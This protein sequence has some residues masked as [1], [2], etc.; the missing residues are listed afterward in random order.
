[1]TIPTLPRPLRPIFIHPGT[2][3]PPTLPLP[4]ASTSSTSPPTPPFIPIICLSASTFIPHGGPEPKRDVYGT[5]EYVQGSGD[6]DEL[7][8][9]GLKPG[10]FFR[11]REEI[12][13][14]S[15]EELPELIA[16]LVERGQ[17]QAGSASVTQGL[18]VWKEIPRGS[19]IWLGTTASDLPKDLGSCALITFEKSDKPSIETVSSDEASTS[20]QLVLRLQEGKKKKIDLDYATQVLPAVV[21]FAR[22]VRSQDLN[23]YILIRDPTGK[24]LS[25]GAAIC[26]SWLFVQSDRSLRPISNAEED[27]AVQPPSLPVPT[28]ED[29]RKRLEWILDE[30]QG[31]NPSRHVLKAVNEYLISAKY[32]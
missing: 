2:S 27:G 11:N 24:S 31:V 7:W 10:H 19:K 20:K 23:T 5:F 3:Y 17:N 30:R 6:D 8:G 9:K 22:R 25:V 4:S 28:K 15:R 26:L 13:S 14:A 1:L 21:E 32:K 18:G 16:R 12:L 29:L